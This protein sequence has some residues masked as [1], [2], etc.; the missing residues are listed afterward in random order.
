[1][2]EG[3]TSVARLTLVSVQ[4]F[5]PLQVWLATKFVGMALNFGWYSISIWEEE[6][7]RAAA[8]SCSSLVDDFHGNARN[9]KRSLRSLYGIMEEDSEIKQLKSQ[10]RRKIFSRKYV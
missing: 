10:F 9:S 5:M 8:L 6:H 7:L 1:M 4:R 2:P 3:N